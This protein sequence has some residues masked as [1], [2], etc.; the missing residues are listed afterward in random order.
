MSHI[1]WVLPVI[2]FSIAWVFPWSYFQWDSSISVSYIFDIVFVAIV[3][4]SLR[5]FNFRF[6]FQPRGLFARSVAVLGAASFSLFIINL[7]GLKAPFKYVDHLF[8]QILILAPII[9]ELVFRQAFFGAFQ[10]YF[11][12]ENHN[13]ILNSFLFSV[14]HLPA[15]WFLPPEFKS[16]IF[17]QLIY[18]FLLGWMCAKSR[19]KSKAVYEPILLHFLFNLVFYLAVTKGII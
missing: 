14:S 15:I 18:T 1:I 2:Y 13:L 9:E 4:F 12:K 3:T 6:Y 17:V 7:F 19:L 5:L 10:K 16:F 11:H 8:L